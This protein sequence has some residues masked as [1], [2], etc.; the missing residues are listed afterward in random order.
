[1][2]DDREDAGDGESELV[3]DWVGDG[4]SSEKDDL[5]G[6]RDTSIESGRY[7]DDERHA[8]EGDGG[9][10]SGERSSEVVE[11]EVAAEKGKQEGDELQRHSVGEDDIGGEGGDV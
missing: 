1:M 5:E 7:G 10:G 4:Q 11:D 6:S 8:G 2:A 9:G 3:G